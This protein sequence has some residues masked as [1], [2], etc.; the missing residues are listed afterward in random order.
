M[1]IIVS[2]RVVLNQVEIFFK[3]EKCY[4][5]AENNYIPDSMAPSGKKMSAKA[6]QAAAE[7]EKARVRAL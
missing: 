1:K 7:K 4:F 3:R 2:S 5:K 6:K